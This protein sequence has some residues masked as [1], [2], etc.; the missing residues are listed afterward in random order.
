MN[1]KLEELLLQVE[2]PAQYIGS[3]INAEYKEKGNYS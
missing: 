3:E 2:K 1:H